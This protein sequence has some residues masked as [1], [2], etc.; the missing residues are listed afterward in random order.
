MEENG[1]INMGRLV[2][3]FSKI[4]EMERD[5]EDMVADDILD[6][7][8]DENGN[9]HY[10]LTDKYYDQIKHISDNIERKTSSFDE[11]C[12]LRGIDQRAIH[13]YRSMNH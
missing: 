3:Q 6:I 7:F 9:F 1:F 13:S 8:V 5:I 4:F 2:Q 11:M 12:L 10:K